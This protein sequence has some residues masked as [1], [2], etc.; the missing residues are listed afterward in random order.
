MLWQMPTPIGQAL[1]DRSDVDCQQ[2]MIIRR[3]LV[4]SEVKS[5]GEFG[6]NVRL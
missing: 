4:N 2:V 3:R 6:E 5:N 1:I